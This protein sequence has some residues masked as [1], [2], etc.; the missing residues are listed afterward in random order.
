MLALLLLLAGWGVP[1][2]ARLCR[3]ARAVDG[4]DRAAALLALAVRG[5]PLAQREWGMAMGA[6]LAALQRPRSRRRFAAGC[7]WAAIVLRLRAG[8]VAPGRGG[9]GVRALVLSA[10]AAALGLGVYGAARYPALRAGFAGWAAIAAFAALL[11]VYAAAALSLSR[12][13][14]PHVVLA[15]R[16]GVAG[17]LAVGASWLSIVM[18]AALSKSFVAL[19]LFAALLVPAAVG[20]LVAR[21]TRQARAGTEAALWSGMAGAL[22]AFTV[23]VSATYASDGRPYDAQLIR[24]FRHSG[25]RDLAAYAIGDNLGAAIGLLVIIPVVALALGSLAARFG[26]ASRT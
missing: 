7:M 9:G 5:L 2:L 20:T 12:G 19:P 10:I 25:A 1:A 22:L 18:P 4:G 8:I 11:L 6:E 24:D 14:A 17:G 3:S 26:V 23:W 13:A 15:R 21:S 16:G